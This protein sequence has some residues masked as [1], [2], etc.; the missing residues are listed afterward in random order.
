MSFRVFSV[1]S[2]LRLCNRT[3]DYIMAFWSAHL[4]LDL[5]VTGSI[6]AIGDGVA[7]G[8]NDDQALTV[9]LFARSARVKK[10]KLVDPIK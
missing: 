9:F 1:W 7:L 6:L 8:V 3:N 5:R 2:D 4:A 10:V